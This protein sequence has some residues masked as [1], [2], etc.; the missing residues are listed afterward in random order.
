MT[1][2]T[3]TPMKPPLNKEISIW[4]NNTDKIDSPLK[5]LIVELNL[6][7]VDTKSNFLSRLL[8]NIN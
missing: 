3:S 4:K 8:Y 2:K 7:F 5:E 6:L 1:K